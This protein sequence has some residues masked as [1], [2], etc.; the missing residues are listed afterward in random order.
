MSIVMFKNHAPRTEQR[1][2]KDIST[3]VAKICSPKQ[4]NGYGRMNYDFAWWLTDITTVVHFTKTELC[5]TSICRQCLPLWWFPSFPDLSECKPRLKG[6]F[7]N[8]QKQ[9][10]FCVINRTCSWVHGSVLIF[11]HLAFVTP[12]TKSMNKSRA[13]MSESR[14]FSGWDAKVAPSCADWKLP[15]VVPGTPR[16]VPAASNFNVENQQGFT[17]SLNVRITLCSQQNIWNIV[18]KQSQETLTF[19]A[20]PSLR[21]LCSLPGFWHAAQAF[22]QS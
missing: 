21:G 17:E 19:Q 7:E 16:F 11:L 13:R 3:L 6:S 12:D 4:V 14:E 1:E 20:T 9:S 22:R 10:F 15:R 5:W 18:Y 8:N 2:H